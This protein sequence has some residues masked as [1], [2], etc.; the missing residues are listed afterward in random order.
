[1]CWAMSCGARR[2]VRFSQASSQEFFAICFRNAGITR[3]NASKRTAT[4]WERRSF[5]PRACEACSR[6]P[7]DCKEVSSLQAGS[8]SLVLHFW[9]GQILKTSH[10]LCNYHFTLCDTLC[11]CWP[12][13]LRLWREIKWVMQAEKTARG[14]TTKQR[15]RTAL[16]L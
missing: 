2:R 3:V 15:G 4:W 1:M 10:V 9:Q 5:A 6:G 14:N 8:V 7:G 16:H 12:N 11:G 13:K